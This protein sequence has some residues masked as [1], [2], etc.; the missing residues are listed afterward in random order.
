MEM[1]LE[2]TSQLRAAAV[3]SRIANTLLEKWKYMRSRQYFLRQML[4][5]TRA[6]CTALLASS[7]PSENATVPLVLPGK[8]PRYEPW[9]RST[10]GDKTDNKYV[11]IR[12]TYQS[13]LITSNK[14]FCNEKRA[15]CIHKR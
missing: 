1:G 4:L 14:S 2:H 10:Q 6:P 15:S 13:L 5:H 7:T 12:T 9:P 3:T 11:L 8:N